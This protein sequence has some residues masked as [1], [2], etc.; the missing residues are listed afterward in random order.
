MLCFNI[1]CCSPRQYNTKYTAKSMIN[2]IKS[3]NTLSINEKDFIDCFKT[4]EI[5]KIII[6]YNSTY[7]NIFNNK[8]FISVLFINDNIKELILCDNKGSSPILYPYDYTIKV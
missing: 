4:F 7:Y 5:T 8:L 6:N 2:I 3:K 1:L